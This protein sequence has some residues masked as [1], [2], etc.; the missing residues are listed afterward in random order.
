MSNVLMFGESMSHRSRSVPSAWRMS[1]FWKSTAALWLLA[2]WIVACGGPE[3]VSENP[4]PVEVVAPG[5]EIQAS[6]MDGEVLRRTAWL[7]AGLPL[8]ELSSEEVVADETPRQ[9]IWQRHAQEMDA[10]WEIIEARHLAP[11]RQWGE[12]A[13]SAAQTEPTALFY[14]FGGPD[15][16]S[17][18]QFFPDAPQFVLVG[19]EPAGTLP[20]LEAFSDEV[21]EA[22]LERLRDGLSNLAEKGY[23]VAR[24]MVQDFGEAQRLEGFVPVLYIFLAR[25]GHVATS[26]RFFDLEADGSMLYRDRLTVSEVYGVE[27]AFVPE[28][29]VE[30]PPRHLYYM[31][32]DLSDEGLAAVP[33]FEAFVRQLGAF[34]VYMKSAMYLPHEEEFGD[35]ETLMFEGRSILQ[36]DSGV[37]FH[38]FDADNWDIDLFGVYTKTLANYRQYF[39][40]DLVDA[41]GPPEDDS[42]LPFAIGYNSR[43]DGSCLIWARRKGAL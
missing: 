37:P 27:L 34:D 18:H 35:L 20:D 10:L 13:L 7:L 40:Q 29:D 17:V 12:T 15:L 19:L 36:D 16:P 23:F 32:Q 21:L 42:K 14:P 2:P 11:M 8:S 22:E 4:A 39:Q 5:V 33:G 6:E 31:A 1:R 38:R 41:Y 3:T 24:H 26:V 28:D 25:S 30:A 43:L 9:A